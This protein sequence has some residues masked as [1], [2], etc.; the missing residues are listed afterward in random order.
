MSPWPIDQKQMTKSEKKY[1]GEGIKLHRMK[2]G[3]SEPHGQTRK[4]HGHTVP[5]TDGC[6]RAPFSSFLSL[7]SE[8]HPSSEPL[9]STSASSFA[10]PQPLTAG[11]LM[12]PV[13]R[14]LLAPLSSL[15]LYRQRAKDRRVLC[16]DLLS[17]NCRGRSFDIKKQPT[18]T[19]RTTARALETG[20]PSDT[21]PRT[22]E[23]MEILS[24]RSLA[25]PASSKAWTH[26]APRAGEVVAEG[27]LCQGPAWAGSGAQA[28]PGALRGGKELPLEG[29]GRK[30]S[31]GNGSGRAQLP[32]LSH[33]P[34][35]A[36]NQAPSRCSE[37]AAELTRIEAGAL[38]E[39]GSA[40]HGLAVQGRNT[41][42]PGTAALSMGSGPHPTPPLTRSARAHDPPTRWAS[43]SC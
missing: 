1:R 11:Q 40:N 42:T 8:S 36:P 14:G 34:C 9:G 17:P 18:T 15:A 32:L 3:V 7:L 33:P 38:G 13:P 2:E 10:S 4:P 23:I 6:P 19:A 39:S 20:L 22:W 41:H 25:M 37:T 43:P 5:Q 16:K 29:D 35:L 31:P 24:G 12:P 28:G 30:D 27:R 26:P 21:F